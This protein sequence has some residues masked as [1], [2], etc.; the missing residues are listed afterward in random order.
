MPLDFALFEALHNLAGTSGA[1]NLLIVFAGKYLGPLM[2]V[3]FVV[4]LFTHAKTLRERLWAGSF[5]FLTVL[6]SRA[7]FT[8]IIRFFYARP[9][10][11]AVLGFEPLFVHAPSLAFPSGHMAFFFALAL[12][13][14]ALHKRWGWYFIIGASLI[15]IARI[16]AGVHWPLDILAGA[17]VAGL[18][19]MIVKEFLP[20]IVK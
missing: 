10:P 11:F 1:F 5:A 14:F 8:E 3:G 16:A 18:S 20:R 19:F 6:L 4:L 7:L 13:V 15:G 9:R 2:L 17:L 12:A